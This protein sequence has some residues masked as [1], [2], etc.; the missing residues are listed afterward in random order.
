MLRAWLTRVWNAGSGSGESSEHPKMTFKVASLNVGRLKS[1]GS[2][3]V[4]TMF[5]RR[6]DICAIQEHRWAGGTE[7]NQSRILKSKN[8]AYKFY[9]CGNKSGLGGARALLA[10]KWTHNVFEV[11]RISD[12]ILVLGLVLRESVF[13]FVSV[14]APQVSRP[15]EEKTIFHDELQKF[16][17]KVPSSEIFILLGDW[18][19]H[20]GEKA[21]WF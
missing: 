21:G 4:E 18:N 8:S 5:R 9:W 14:Y 10:E 11:H 20:V 19:G 13:T 12:R 1:R 2:E 7:S 6:V 15:N 17:S 3:V 16:I